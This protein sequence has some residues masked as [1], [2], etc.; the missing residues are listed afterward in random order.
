[1]GNMN[2]VLTRGMLKEALTEAFASF[3]ERLVGKFGLIDERFERIDERFE[4][5]DQRFES[6]EG[7][8]GNLEARMELGFFELNERLDA[9]QAFTSDMWDD[10]STRLAA[11]EAK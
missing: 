7:K 1:M 3:E 9:E 4:R 2:E 8:L 11:L 10:F 6:I 5:I